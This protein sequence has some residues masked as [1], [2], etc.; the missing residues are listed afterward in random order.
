[1]KN[2]VAE[3]EKGIHIVTTEYV[4]GYKIKEVKGLVW[5]SSVRAKSIL[6]DLIAMARITYGG[7]VHEYW[8]LINEARHEILIKLNRNAK[9][10]GANAIVDINLVTSQVVPGT[11]EIM[12]YGTAVLIE[13][14]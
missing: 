10:I 3:K 12:A 14:E 4:P 5:A 1:M 6:K 8:E 2:L 7:E 13:K 11:I 9:E